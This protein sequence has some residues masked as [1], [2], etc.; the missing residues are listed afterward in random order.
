MP[1]LVK[2]GKFIYGLSRIGP[3]GS[4]IIPPQ[5]MSEYGFKADDNVI[6]MSGSR[7]SGGFALTKRSIVEKSALSKIIHDLPGLFNNLIP[8]KEIVIYQR[9]AFCRTV[10]NSNGNIDLPGAALSR[11]DINTGDVLAAGRGSYLSI[12]F[13][14]RGPIFEECLRH[15]ELQVFASE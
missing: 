9:R 5:A 7:R 13:I 3:G 15:P 11:Y 1:Q 10:I 8:E 4:I 6:L 14:A 2:G 12:A